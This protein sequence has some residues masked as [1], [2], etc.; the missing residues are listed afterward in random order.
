MDAAADLTAWLRLLL[1]PGVGRDLARRLLA[2]FGSAEAVFDASPAALK[3]F[4]TAAQLAS[5]RRVPDD[6]AERVAATQ[7]WLAAGTAR[8]CITV[9]DADF[10]QILL[11]TE[12][13]PLL[14]FAQGRL[15]VLQH[16]A[17]AVV[18][19][20]NPTPQGIE[21]ARAFADHLGASG[22]CI[23]SGLALGIDAAA[24]AG[25][26]AH[27]GSTIA[28]VGTGLDR[29]YPSRHRDLAHA[30]ATDGLLLSEFPI[31]TPPLRENFPRRN[32]VIAGL[33]RG[34]LVVE[35][36]LKSG[37]LIT[38]RHALEAGR[39]VFAIP[40]SIHSPLARGCHAL[41]K[42]GARLVES[43]ADILDELGGSGAAAAPALRPE[44]PAPV[45]A[46]AQGGAEGGAHARLLGHMG[47]DP[48][49][50]DALLARSGESAS[51][52]NAQLLE[53]ELAGAVCRLAGGLFQRV[54]RA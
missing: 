31:G 39:E 32:R 4:T 13:P 46:D 14:L 48:V 22:W 25:G 21:N 50:L 1:S 38:A 44:Q 10:P 9:G 20:R 36:A 33:A 8:H 12:D 7:D 47:H 27:A 16:P 18:G 5:L 24:H 37:S 54:A 45:P 26:L 11:Q 41:I 40:G 52:L 30:I 19:S 15:E 28:V 53:L 35:A 17:L 49:T 3:P 29:V 23:V 34:T 43:A 51:T 6:L 42:Q 2:A